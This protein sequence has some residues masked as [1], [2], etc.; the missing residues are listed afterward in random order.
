MNEQWKLDR[1]KAMKKENEELEK[2]VKLSKEKKCLICG[3]LRS[4]CVC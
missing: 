3:A 4:E 1:I 2:R